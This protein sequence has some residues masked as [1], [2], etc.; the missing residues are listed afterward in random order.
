M[1]RTKK[2]AEKT[3]KI[4]KSITS[5][6]KKATSKKSTVSTKKTT[7]STKASTKTTPVK[8][9]VSKEKKDTSPKAVKSTKKVTVKKTTTAKKST[10]KVTST[11]KATKTVKTTKV[12]KPKAK[13]VKKTTS[14][15]KKSVEKDFTNVL[16][17]YDLPYRYNETTVKILAQ[18][19]KVLF[20]YWD[21]SDDDR[22]N[23]TKK[24]GEYF[25]NDTY[26]VLIVHNKTLD[27]FQEVEINDF[28]N[29]WYL[30]IPDARC[31]YS[32][33]LGRRFK[34]YAK[35]NPNMN[36]KEDLDK[37]LPITSSN[38]LVMP[39]DRVLIDEIKPQVKYRNV[40]TNKE[41]YKSILYILQNKNYKLFDYYSL[42]KEMYQVEDISRLFNLNNPSSA[43]NPTSTFK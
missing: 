22:A 34:E 19:P 23:L 31:E 29:S 32:I 33:E 41:S 21:I 13:T 27:Y 10:K 16:E 37:V 17:Y 24:Y 4:E 7:K 40:K 3:E 1:P 28:A 18:T 8:K 6:T 42:Y 20:V 26:P 25:F 43:G 2:E 14:R 30:S 11:P 36:H 9:A 15:I 38:D 35:R 39:N 5:A 12:T